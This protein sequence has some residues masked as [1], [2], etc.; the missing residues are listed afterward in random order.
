MDATVKEFVRYLKATVPALKLV[1]LFGSR[2]GSEFHAESDIDL[3]LL[4]DRALTHDEM[5][6]LKLEATRLFE[7]PMDLID[8]FTASLV[9]TFQVIESGVVL[10][11]ADPRVA[12]DFET[13]ALA[14]YC[15]LN[16][17]RKELL[18][19][20]QARGFIHA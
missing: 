10:F 13:T 8:L 3:A 14:K 16:Q 2:A 1:Y 7:E 15:C 12:G 5:S 18:K 19:A 9:L 17:E 4:A 6:A 11:V 20:I